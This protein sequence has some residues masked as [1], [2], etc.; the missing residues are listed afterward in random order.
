VRLLLL[1]VLLVLSACAAQPGTGSDGSVA[2]TSD[3]ER[4]GDGSPGNEL[5]IEVDPGDGSAAAAYTLAC[6]GVAGGDHPAAQE[7]CDHL[8]AMTDPFA[9]LP[10]DAMC[11]QVYDGP[12]TAHV[13][14]RWRGE[15]VDLEVGR[16]NGCRTA[17]WDGLGPL[18][19]G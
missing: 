15:P 14:G 19:P 6:D 3:P 7:A 8:R 13:T 10:A 9:P 12:Q 5:R 1:V 11:T 2:S 16:N 17:Q 18:L 4:S